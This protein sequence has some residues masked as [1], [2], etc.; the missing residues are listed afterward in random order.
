MKQAKVTNIT[1]GTVELIGYRR[2]LG[3]A[4]WAM[5]AEPVSEEVMYQ[6]GQKLLRIERAPDDKPRQVIAEGTLH[7]K[8]R[9]KGQPQGGI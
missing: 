4:E 3:P 2:V 9:D 5:V 8:R 6:V 7:K 1:S